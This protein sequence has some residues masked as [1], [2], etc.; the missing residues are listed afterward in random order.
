[1]A[2]SAT[3]ISETTSK[4][5]PATWP[6]G[7]LATGGTYGLIAGQFQSWTTRPPRA[8]PGTPFRKRILPIII[9]P[10]FLKTG[11]LKWA[12]YGFLMES[13]YTLIYPSCSL[14]NMLLERELRKR[15]FDPVRQVYFFGSELT[16]S[17]N[18]ALGGALGATA[19]AAILRLRGTQPLVSGWERYVG[20]ASLG[21]FAGHKVRSRVR[22]HQGKAILE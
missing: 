22:I 20:A 19:F 16:S 1:M 3:E 18:W 7:D 5:L 17:D 10:F 15:E 8:A 2:T 4:H 21:A 6:L 14:R 11:Y 9:K 13:A 12:A